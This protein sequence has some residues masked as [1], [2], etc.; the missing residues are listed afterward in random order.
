MYLIEAVLLAAVNGG[1]RITW[2]ILHPTFPV[3]SNIKQSEK[4][5]GEKRNVQR[6]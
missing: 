1:N 6:V 4:Q 2:H 3:G 5:Y